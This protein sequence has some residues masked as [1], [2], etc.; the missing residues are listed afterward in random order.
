[1]PMVPMVQQ[2]AVTVLHRMIATSGAFLQVRAGRAHD[3][4]DLRTVVQERRSLL[5]QHMDDVQ[6]ELVAA[7]C[8]RMQRLK[9]GQC[10]WAWIITT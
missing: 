2:R 6:F 8:E 3:G 7:A 10:E 4:R 1:M 9:N 5:L